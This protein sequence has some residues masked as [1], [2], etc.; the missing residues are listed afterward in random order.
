MDPDIQYLQGFRATIVMTSIQKYAETGVTTFNYMISFS[1][2]RT[3]GN[4]V[5]LQ[6]TIVY[7]YTNYFK[8]V[9]IEAK[10]NDGYGIIDVCVDLNTCHMT[11][12]EAE[13]FQ[14][15]RAHFLS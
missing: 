8:S 3:I 2:I 4:R 5:R 13:A 1:D 10:V 6:D 12:A 7:K 14:A 15:A 11:A 9:G